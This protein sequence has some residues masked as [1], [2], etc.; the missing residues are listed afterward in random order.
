MSMREINS[1]TM[2]QNCPL[3]CCC[4]V[5]INFCILALESGQHLLYRLGSGL[6]YV[7]LFYG[8]M[9]L[10]ILFCMC[11]LNLTM[12]TASRVHSTVLIILGWLDGACNGGQWSATDGMLTLSTVCC[13]RTFGV[14]TSVTLWT[15]RNV[16]HNCVL[17]LYDLVKLTCLKIT[18]FAHFRFH[19]IYNINFYETKISNAIS[20]Y[21][22][23][24]LDTW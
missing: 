10:R 11:P 3:W 14:V 6:E 4:H 17:K 20:K 2:L 9:L 13:R 16:L 15:L 18:N 19:W 8:I 23:L 1:Y 12:H 5:I 22:N 24:I 21:L 7:S